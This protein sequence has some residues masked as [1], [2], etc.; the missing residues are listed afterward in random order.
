M[1][2]MKNRNF[3]NVALAVLLY[4]AA[5]PGFAQSDPGC[6]PFPRAAQ[7][8]AAWATPQGKVLLEHLNALRSGDKARVKRTVVADSKMWMSVKSLEAANAD[9]RLAALQNLT[10]DPSTQELTGIFTVR[11]DASIAMLASKPGGGCKGAM[12]YPI[13]LVNGK[14]LVGE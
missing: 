8:K 12:P 13:T 6:P 9:E 5:A 3:K 2:A 10:P 11:P 14:W 4:A 1:F 7:G